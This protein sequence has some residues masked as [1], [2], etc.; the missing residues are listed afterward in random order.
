M[1]SQITEGVSIDVETYYLYDQSNPLNNEYFFA[2]K[3]TISNLAKNTVQLH[4]R[5]WDIID[6]NGIHRIVDGEGVVGQQGGAPAGFL[7]AAEIGQRRHRHVLQ[8][9]VERPLTRGVRVHQVVDGFVVQER[10]G[11]RGGHVRLVH[12]GL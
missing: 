8:V 2:Y 5:H 6:S 9:G 1:V 3:I 7:L 10:R 4:S 11:D 12:R